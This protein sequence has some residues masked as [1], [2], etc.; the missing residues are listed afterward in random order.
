MR[1]LTKLPVVSGK[2]AVKV[3]EKDGWVFDRQ[4]GSHAI[5]KKAGSRR[6][7]SIPLHDELDRGLL[8]HLIRVASM[9]VEDFCDLLGK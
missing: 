7:L 5:L 6:V 2:E 3:F 1:R 8:R 9:T 4:K